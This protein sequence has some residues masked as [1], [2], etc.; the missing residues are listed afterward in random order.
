MLV[1][2]IFVYYRIFF[3]NFFAIYLMILL[4]FTKFGN[5]Y[6]WRHIFFLLYRHENFV[7]ES[8][9]AVTMPL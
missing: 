4:Y 1:Q 2:I 9:C 3:F 7:L 6:L 5:L 8:H